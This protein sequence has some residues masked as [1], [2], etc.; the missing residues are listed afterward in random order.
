[1]TDRA[2]LFVVLICG[3]LALTSRCSSAAAQPDDALDLARLAVHE[4]GWEHPAEA[5]AIYAVAVNGAERTGM[6]WP[7]WLRVHSRR[8]AARQVTRSWVY[9]LDRRGSDP[10]AGIS[11][12]A[13]RD[14]WLAILA[15]ADAA[16][17]APPVCV[18]RTWGSAAD[19]ARVVRLGLPL[20]PVSCGVTRNTYFARRAR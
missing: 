10:H 7:R 13:H 5:A 18:A 20:V 6:T 3:L 2:P 8:F 11:W 16:I 14:R 17:A 9:R 19:A 1:V 15:A 4:S 12:A